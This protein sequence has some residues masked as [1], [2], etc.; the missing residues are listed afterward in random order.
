MGRKRISQERAIQIYGS[1]ERYEKHCQYMKEYNIKHAEE[2]AAWRNEHKAH[3]ADLSNKWRS[4]HLD[5]YKQKYKE[6]SKQRRKRRKERRIVVKSAV[7]KLEKL[8]LEN[9]LR[10]ST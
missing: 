1:L 9:P 8:K 6:R 3:L 4:T 10:E 2:E 5:E 7:K